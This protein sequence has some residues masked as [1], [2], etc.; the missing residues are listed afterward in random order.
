MEASV[1]LSH[2][3]DGAQK[4]KRN[5]R[6]AIRSVTSTTIARLRAL[7]SG[8][9]TRPAEA[10][11]VGEQGTYDGTGSDRSGPPGYRRGADHAVTEPVCMG[12][13]RNA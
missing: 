4:T 2:S 1:L 8:L 6:D 10:E 7:G 12:V 13:G 5:G 3:G 9:A 11:P